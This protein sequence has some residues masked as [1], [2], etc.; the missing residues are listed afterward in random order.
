MCVGD[1]AQ[2]PKLPPKQLTSKKSATAAEPEDLFS[3]TNMNNNN[4]K[5]TGRPS[6]LSSLLFPPPPPYPDKDEEEKSENQSLIST[7][8][9]L[10]PPFRPP[11]P[12]H[13]KI[14]IRKHETFS[15]PHG[16]KIK[17]PVPPKSAAVVRS[18]SLKSPIRNR[19]PGSVDSAFRNNLEMLR[20]QGKPESLSFL[21]KKNVASLPLNRLHAISPFKPNYAKKPEEKRL[22]AVTPPTVPEN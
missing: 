8:R 14:G 21:Q 6:A 12:P 13:S 4:S 2:P 18:A 16:G 1:G 20:S 9:S 22:V 15:G 3:D 5:F 10:T 17:P 19:P 11:T 7:P